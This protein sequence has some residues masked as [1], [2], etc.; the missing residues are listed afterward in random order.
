MAKSKSIKSNEGEGRKL[1]A[2]HGRKKHKTGGES[3]KETGAQRG[4]SR[5]SGS[6]KKH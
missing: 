6:S 5:R 3:Q 4:S 2:G 1:A